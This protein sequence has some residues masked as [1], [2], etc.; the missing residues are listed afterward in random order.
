MAARDV[1]FNVTANDKTGTALASA[2]RKFKESQRRI[3]GE[4]KKHSTRMAKVLESSLGKGVQN[5]GQAIGD[6]FENAGKIIVPLLG[7]GV[8]AAS[9]VIAATLSAAIAAGVSIGVAGIGVA[10]VSQDARVKAAG[11]Q[12]GKSLFSSLQQDA[13]P[14]IG[15]VLHAIDTIQA[16]FNDLRPT[17]QRIFANASKFVAPLVGG[18]THAIEA[19]IGGVD[20]L[21]AKSGGI[22]DETSRSIGK[23]GD[24][25]GNFLANINTKDAQ[26]AIQGLTGTITGLID[27]LGPLFNI[28]TKVYALANRFGLTGLGSLNT[29]LHKTGTITSRVAGQTDTLATSFQG[30]ADDTY[31]YAA[32]LDQAK[33]A[34]QG[35]Y[36]AN[37][38][39][40]GS[41]TAVEKAFADAN[42]VVKENGKILDANKPKGQA[43]REALLGV[44]EALQRNYDGYVKVNGEG[45]GAATLAGQLRARF[46]TLA[47]KMG[48]SSTEAKRLADKLLGI[49]NV[50]RKVD[51]KTAQ[52]NAAAEALKTKLAGIQDRTVYIT[53]AFNQGR[54]NKVQAQ[55]DRIGNFPYSASTFSQTDTSSGSSR[56]GGASPVNVQSTVNNVITLDG[57]PFRQYT[58][59]QIEQSTNRNAWRTRVGTK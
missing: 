8:A 57:A 11:S 28:L 48:A 45:K 34:V 6:V 47:E 21:I 24:S 25:V 15:P 44:A 51:V 18:I 46:V 29:N 27:I 30:V 23:I 5:V 38:D 53:A 31:D 35:L 12:L 33:A 20:K 56:T 42:A 2:E 17:I 55:L 16:R 3:E 13:A 37:R 7:Y 14:F 49:P 22:V 39:L 1:E 40:Y 50:N 26:G 10:L 36:S 54:I 32:G 19:V 4:N 52:A 43:N 9:P 41:T 58:A 59:R